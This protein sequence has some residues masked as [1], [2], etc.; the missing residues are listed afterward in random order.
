M[1]FTFK[2]HKK[3]GQYRSFQKDF[4]DIKLRGHQ[5]GT[6]SQADD[7][8]LYEIRFAVHNPDKTSN[9]PFIWKTLKHRAQSEQE[10]REFVQTHIVT[11]QEKFNLYSFPND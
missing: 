2:K 1:K 5:V 10:A 4:T 9:C 8:R 7:Y 11:I 3:E 6:I